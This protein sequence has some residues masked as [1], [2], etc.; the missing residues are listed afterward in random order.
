MLGQSV[1]NECEHCLTLLMQKYLCQLITVEYINYL[2]LTKF[3]KPCFVLDGF[4]RLSLS[5]DQA[6]PLGKSRMGMGPLRIEPGA[7]G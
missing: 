4:H 3:T 1:N 2:S 7:D 5:T 6:V